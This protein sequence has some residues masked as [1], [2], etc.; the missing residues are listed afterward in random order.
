[1]GKV[2]SYTRIFKG[3]PHA[4]IWRDGKFEYKGKLYGSLM[5]VAK[6][7]TGYSNIDG[8]KFFGVEPLR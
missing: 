3:R 1:M 6:K 4:A 5:A 2:I 8:R 7:I